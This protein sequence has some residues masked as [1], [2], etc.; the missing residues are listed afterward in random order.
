[1]VPD[2]QGV[3]FRKRVLR[4]IPARGAQ[5]IPR[6]GGRRRRGRGGGK[7]PRGRGAE[8]ATT[9]VPVLRIVIAPV[10]PIWR[11]E[12]GPGRE[13]ALSRPGPAATG[14]DQTPKAGG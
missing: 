13:S 5:I 4:P 8:P 3:L 2:R 12:A 11:K 1:M 7:G 6:R 14:P 9:F 10:R